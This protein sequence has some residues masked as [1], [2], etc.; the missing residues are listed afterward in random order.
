MTKLFKKIVSLILGVIIGIVAVSGA[1]VASAYYLY[2]RVTVGDM[3]ENRYKDSLGDVNEFSIADLVNYTLAARLSPENYTFKDMRDSLRFDIVALINALGGDGSEVIKSGEDGK[4]E[5]YVDDLRS[6]SLF[7]LL[8]SDGFKKF[9]EDLP[10]G[11]VL[12]FIDPEIA[13]DYDARAR[14]RSYTLGDLIKKDGETGFSGYISA[15]S[16]VSVG[17]VLSSLFTK[18]ENGDYAVKDGLNPAFNLLANV[19]FGAILN[20][21]KG[22]Y[23]IGAEIV[24][25][26]LKTLG[27]TPFTEIVKTLGFGENIAEIVGSALSD[28]KFKDLFSKDLSTGR[29]AFSLDALLENVGVGAFFGFSCD[30]ETGKWYSSYGGEKTEVK[31]LL[32]V[33]ASLNAKDLYHAFA[34]GGDAFG[35]IRS[36]LLTVGDLTIGDILITSGFEKGD[37]GAWY[38]GGSPVFNSPVI[39]VILSVPL[40]ATIA[41]REG[42]NFGFELIRKNLFLYCAAH[43]GDLTLGDG[44]AELF[45][46]ANTDDGYV[47]TSGE[48]EGIKVN[49]VI[50]DLFGI[51]ASDLFAALGG[52]KFTYKEMLAAVAAAYVAY[53][54][55]TGLDYD[56][57]LD[58]LDDA[59]STR[60]LGV[61]FGGTETDGVWYDADGN[62]I[63]GFNAVYYGISFS[64]V[65]RAMESLGKEDFSLGAVA[66]NILPDTRLG[67]LFAGY[68]GYT[69][70]ENGIYLNSDGK[71]ASSGLQRL[72][73]IK[74]WEL[75]AG[76]DPA[77][78]F[79]ITEDF[80][81]IRIGDLFDFTFDDGAVK[82]WY[83]GASDRYVYGKLGEILSYTLADLLASEGN[84]LNDI[85]EKIYEA[86]LGD[87]VALAVED[88]TFSKILD[89]LHADIEIFGY[90]Y[91]ASGDFNEVLNVTFNLTVSEIAA[92][93]GN[94]LG[95]VLDNYGDMPLGNF[96]GYLFNRGMIKNQLGI[97]EIKHEGGGWEVVGP[98]EH[99]L[100]ILFDDLTLRKLYDGRSDVKG[101]IVKGYF[102]DVYLGEFL[103]ARKIGGV[104]YKADGEPMETHGANA[105]ITN[106]VYS[107]TVEQVIDENF[108]FSTV[109]NDVYLGEL[110]NY[111]RCEE[112]GGEIAC[113]IEEHGTHLLGGWYKKEGNEY[114]KVGAIENA[115]SGVTV[116]EMTSG[117][118]SFA[119]ALGGVKVGEVMEYTYSGGVWYDKDGKRVDKL[120]SIIADIDMGEV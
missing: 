65:I 80:S 9:F 95:F 72:F 89:K 11:A 21:L 10:A 120:Q 48:N 94:L 22:N 3:T 52:E 87:I 118:F 8:S 67:E 40:K 29:Y 55:G 13:L 111:Y 25:G 19:E 115:V 34:D 62:R 106:A 33:L 109:I 31:G 6:V 68:L 88:K 93:A 64:G 26:G 75:A 37:D 102:G 16:E 15:L 74:V 46:A 91:A 66:R 77:D 7:T 51:K 28:I 73:G 84:R 39:D 110:M 47:F 23:D 105:V 36:A 59:L 70:D 38:F 92:G 12:S 98:Y 108:D 60:K 18:D 117:S 44:F 96:L 100:T 76:F 41:E 27:N 79:D 45:G 35:K 63:D 17:S 57:I 56:D 113:D 119:D 1:L 24:E 2:T 50:S 53:S 32:A 82:C 30:A 20:I 14:L 42:E 58:V 90:E 43:S 104:W 81:A 116:G 83:T 86:R 4:N 5:P 71:E 97:R 103:G 61:L 49:P 107:L 54:A 78:G 112:V 85:Y 99:P 114:E 101:N 69:A